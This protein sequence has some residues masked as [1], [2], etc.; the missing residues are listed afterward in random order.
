[1]DD[2]GPRWLTATPAHLLDNS[3]NDKQ[4]EAA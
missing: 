2:Q 4:E 3:N 1:M